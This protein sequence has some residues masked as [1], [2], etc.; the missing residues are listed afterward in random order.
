MR[1]TQYSPGCAPRE[2]WDPNTHNTPPTP[3]RHTTEPPIPKPP[4][5]E[6]NPGLAKGDARLRLEDAVKSPFGSLHMGQAG[7]DGASDDWKCVCCRSTRQ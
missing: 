4:P 5:P 7:T 1:L 6:P 3:P 2:R